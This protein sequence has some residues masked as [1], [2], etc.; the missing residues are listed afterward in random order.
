MLIWQCNRLPVR[1]A[2]DASDRS[3]FTASIN[4]VIFP[5]DR[6]NPLQMQTHRTTCFLLE[7]VVKNEGA[8]VVAQCYSSTG[9]TEMDGIYF[10]VAVL[11]CVLTVEGIL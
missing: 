7:V 2:I 6:A 10:L 3:I 11:D 9:W 8:F 1:P 5:L 4:L